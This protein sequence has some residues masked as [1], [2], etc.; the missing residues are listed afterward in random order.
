MHPLIVFT[1]IN[2][3]FKIIGKSSL[4]FDKN[5]EKN[6][7]HLL[8]LVI[9]SKHF[10]KISLRKKDNIFN[11][12]FKKILKK[13]NAKFLFLCYEAENFKAH[14]YYKRNKFKIYKKINNIFFLRKSF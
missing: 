1:N 10:K 12:F 14:E 2:F 3:L 8:H 5:R 6:Y 9:L 13:N 4:D 11:Y 7:I